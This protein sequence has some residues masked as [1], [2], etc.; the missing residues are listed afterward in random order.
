[1]P[2]VICVISTRSSD[3]ACLYLAPV[4]ERRKHHHVQGQWNENNGRY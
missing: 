2:F 1:L 4:Y 3:T